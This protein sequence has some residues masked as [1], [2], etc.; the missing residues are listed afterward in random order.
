MICNCFLLSNRLL[1]EFYVWYKK[2]DSRYLYACFRLCAYKHLSIAK[3]LP[4]LFLFKGEPTKPSITVNKIPVEGE[5]V[6]LTCSSTSTTTPRDPNLRMMYTWKDGNKIASDTRFTYSDTKNK[7]TI[8][9]VA[10]NDVNK[11][12]TCTAKE[13]TSIA[14][15][16]SSSDSKTIDV[17]CKLIQP[18]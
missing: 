13:D 5:S 12:F 10:R 15:T 8:S 1:P 6:T 14:I 18:W 9:N 2:Y 7:L 16:S 3:Y 17:Y 11:Q 4:L